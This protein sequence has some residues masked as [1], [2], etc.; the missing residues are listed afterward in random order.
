MERGGMG[1]E[2]GGGARRMQQRSCCHA[3]DADG[4][5]MSI[6]LPWGVKS[7]GLITSPAGYFL[8]MVKLKLA[9]VLELLTIPYPE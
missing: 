9:T 6:Y 7:V 1:L 8:S 2:G 3:Y 4:T 5:R